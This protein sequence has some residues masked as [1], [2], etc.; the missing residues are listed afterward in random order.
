LIDLVFEIALDYVF[1][2]DEVDE[3]EMVFELFVL[4]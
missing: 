4:A 2:Q 1:E 3:V